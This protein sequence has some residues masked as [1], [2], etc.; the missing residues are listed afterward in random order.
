LPL[1]ECACIKN[2]FR[3]GSF[4]LG[5]GRREAYS[6]YQPEAVTVEGST[7]IYRFDNCTFDVERSELRRNGVLCPLEP[8]VFDLLRFLIENRDRVV[9]RDEIFQAVWRGRIVSDAVLSTRLNAARAAIDDNGREQRLIRTLSRRGIRFTGT[10][11]EE[12]AAISSDL[13]TPAR[14]LAMTLPDAPTL[15]VVPFF[16]LDGDAHGASFADAFTDE[17]ITALWR[18]G[19]LRITTA[20]VARGA[21]GLPLAHAKSRANYFL[22]GSIRASGGQ[23]DIFVRLIEAQSGYHVW[24][25]RFDAAVVTS[26]PAQLIATIEQQVADHIFAAEALR[27]RLAAP[28]NSGIWSSIVAVLALM[29]TR[30]KRKVEA[31]YQLLR[32]ALTI[33][34]QCAPAYALLSFVVTLRVHLGWRSR[35]ASQ[36]EALALAHQAIA[37]DS[38]DAWGHLALGYATM[39]VCNQ[40]EEAIEIL[41]DALRLDPALSVAHYFAA[42]SSAYAGRT[43]NAFAHAD[44]AERLQSCDLLARGNVG[45]Y[46]IVRGTTSFV[47]GRHSEGMAYARAALSKNPRHVPAYRQL[48]TNAASAGEVEQAR[49]ALRALQRLACDTKMFVRES[50][51]AWQN[52]HTYQKVV[53]AFRVAG[54]R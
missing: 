28:A 48:L 41:Q 12:G 2:V 49:N 27:S 36:P 9:S 37:A 53:E 33:D 44:M 18:H 40:P 4:F 22:Q 31:A 46:D 45:A 39:Q 6:R 47:A 1:R 11:H 25:E 17:V 38:D 34:P 50:A 29:N 20:L 30:E 32:R 35:A 26:V 16:D 51:T 15:A 54:L 24:A 7:L 52:P 8:Q 13:R 14:R 3:T 10:V 21:A 5:V 43:D 19:W 42:L 23:I